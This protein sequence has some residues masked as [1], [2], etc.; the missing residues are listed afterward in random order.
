METIAIVGASL[1]GGRAAEALR[2]EG[3]DGR[4]VL[5]GAEPERPYERPPLSKELLWGTTQE[6]R[7][8]LRAEAY[9]A[10]QQIELWL[11]ARASEL[12]PAGRRLQ[13]A[14]GRELAY[15]K[16][17]IT[18]GAA[19]RWLAVTG[20]EL[21]GILVLRTLTDARALRQRI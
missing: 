13:L 8:Y 12:D 18:T 2:Q 6:E 9:Y 19:P 11:G 5:I 15:D 3:F 21:D 14:D 17:L 10:E 4:I 20:S 7:L 16:L 1:A